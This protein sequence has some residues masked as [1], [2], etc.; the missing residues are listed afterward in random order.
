MKKTFAIILTLIGF[1]T[2]GQE[3]KFIEIDN[4][5]NSIESDSTLVELKFD[6]SK[7]TD[8]IKSSNRILRIWHVK[9][10]IFKIVEE[11]S[12]DYGEIKSTIYLN[13]MNP[14]KT[15][16]SESVYYYLPDS[17]AQIKGYDIDLK[18]EFRAVSYITN[19]NK[20]E[21]EL[22]TIGKPSGEKSISF[23]LKKYDAI[24][25]KAKK[26]ISK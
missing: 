4:E 1:L 10:R 21:R 20:K 16:E 12:V 7:K 14:I 19:W 17:I 3:S 24:I 2:F 6:L 26:L 5:A 25:R 22:I 8:S 18:D 13:G 9:K 11:T 23:E 15:I